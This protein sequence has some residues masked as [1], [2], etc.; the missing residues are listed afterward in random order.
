M[1]SDGLY[2]SDRCKRRA[3]ARRRKAKEFGAY[4]TYTWTEVM[5]VF[6]LFDRCCAYCA[7]RIDGEP[8]PDHVIALA[9]G[10]HNTIGN[11]LPA[12]PAC[13]SHKRELSLSEWAEDRACRRMPPRV[14]TWDANDMRYAHLT[15]QSLAH[16]A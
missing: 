9:R 5:K 11:I 2:C 8:E 3:A 6:L 7:V 13:N 10:G 1:N 12:C 14:T 4:G 15:A 16:A